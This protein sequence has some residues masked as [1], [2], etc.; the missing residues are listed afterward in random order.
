MLCGLTR[1]R[2]GRS[3]IFL[4][5]IDANGDERWS[6]A[7]GGEGTAKGPSVLRS[8]DG[9]LVVLGMT[10]SGDAGGADFWLLKLPGNPVRQ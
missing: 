2:K 6:A 7:F 9:C 1:L 5:G 8:D 10:D 3:E 4:V